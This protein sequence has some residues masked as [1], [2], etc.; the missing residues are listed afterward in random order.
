MIDRRHA[1]GLLAAASILPSRS[2]ANVA[3]QRS[4]IREALAKRFLDAGTVGTFVGYKV[5]DYLIIA[6]DKN[7]SGEAKLP[8][9]TFKI[10]NSLI[11]LETGVVEDPDK[12][13]YFVARV[14]AS[15]RG[16]IE[17]ITF[18]EEGDFA[19]RDLGANVPAL[20][21]ELTA[22]S[23]KLAHEN[24]TG[25]LRL[26]LDDKLVQ[27]FVVQLVDTGVRAGFGDIS[28]VPLDKTRR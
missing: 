22:V 20:R 5:D 19:L 4:E 13:K 17:R 14:A 21:D 3:P 1:L 10:P 2:F 25:K 27:G 6:S 7:R 23:T 26:E 16:T 18:G 24:R 8:A 28:P 15:E 12:P 11:A 9:S